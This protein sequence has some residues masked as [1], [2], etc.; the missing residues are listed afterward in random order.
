MFCAERGLFYIKLEEY[1][2]NLTKV[3]VRVDTFLIFIKIYLT[4]Y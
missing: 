3:A 1:A 4:F 2:N